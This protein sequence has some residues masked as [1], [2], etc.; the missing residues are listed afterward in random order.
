MATISSAGLGSGLDVA[1]II[2]QLMAIE[3]QPQNN[4]V[5]AATKIQTQISEVGKITSAVSK[6]RD[7]SSKLSSGTFWQQTSV[8]SSNAAVGVTT[9]SSA[10]AANYSVE[11]QQLAGAQSLLAGQTFVSSSAA[12]GTGT[13]TLEMGTWGA[14]QT[15]FAPRTP[16]A[17][18]S[19][20]VAATDTVE[21]LRDKINAAG[22]G[23][24]A[25]ILT[26]ASGARLVM[27]SKDTG[28]ANGFRVSVGSSPG[29]L[30]LPAPASGGV[31]SLAFD[32]SVGS[33]SASQKTAAANSRATLDGVAV[34]SASNTLPDLLEGLSL[35]LTA[36]T[37]A[38]VNVKV[39]GDTESIKKTLTEFAAAYT[40]LFKLIATDTKY[41]AAARRG[42]PLQ[43]DGAIIAMQGKLRGLLST[44]STGS[45]AYSRL[46]DV[47]LE[48]QRDGSLTVNTTRLDQGLANLPQMRALFANTTVG[49]AGAEGFGRRFR[50]IADDQLNTGGTLTS[51]TSGLNDKLQRNQKSQDAME[52][53]L[54][55]TQKRLQAQ[56]GALDTKIASLNGL[57]G[58]V[59]Q[60]V[61]QWNRPG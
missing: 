34:T 44:G 3:R 15:S 28:A 12:V 58:Y 26:D 25:S 10:L 50:S 43:G 19:V 16:A 60:Q 37:T 21:T 55:Q 45:T 54:A 14:G 52:Q 35:T 41:D 24:T 36:V 39:S 46:S 1:S 30:G 6:L 42:G 4:L 18:A 13:V 7:L 47:G 20:V 8:S 33:N 49:D 38:A 61:A 27:R 9:S 59:S 31:T 11:V 57:A 2:S 23:V 22:L 29:T 48:Q 32:P 56:Y 40:D 5:A 53:R 51:R 17:T